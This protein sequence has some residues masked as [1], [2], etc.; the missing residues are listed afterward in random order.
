MASAKI[1]SAVVSMVVA[2][3]L[4]AGNAV[5][6]DNTSDWPQ[7]RGPNRDGVAP[8]GIK[9]VE[10]WPAKGP[11]QV[12][13]S[14]PIPSGQPGGLGSVAVAGGRAYVYVNWK[15]DKGH[16]DV[17]L[18]FDAATGKEIW[19]KEFPG[20]GYDWGCSAT[21][22]ILDD[23]CYV[24]ASDAKLYCL[25]AADG[26]LVWEAKTKHGGRV[27]SSVLALGSA[28]FA[29][30]GELM[31]FDKDSGK[32]LWS[33]PR[34]KA[35]ENSPVA[36]RHADKDYLI[37]NT[38]GHVFC[39]DASDGRVLWQANGGGCATAVVQG[40]HMV[41]YGNGL[42]AYALTLENALPLWEKN[43]WRDRGASAVIYSDHVYVVGGRMAC[44]DLKSGDVRWEK[45]VG[46]EITSPVLADNM[47][48]SGING[49]SDTVLLKADPAAFK[50]LSRVRL[51]QAAC[52]SPAIAG[53]K[54]FLRLNDGVACYDIQQYGAYLGE[55]SLQKHWLV[56]SFKKADDGLKAKT[57]DEGAIEGLSIT[58]ST[59]AV[60]PAKARVKDN[61]VAVSLKGMK[62]PLEVRY[63]SAT[64]LTTRGGEAV[65]PFR[66]ASTSMRYMR[67]TGNNLTF[68]FDPPVKGE[69]WGR[70]ELYTV[71]GA[72][73]TGVELKADGGSVILTTDKAWT[74]GDQGTVTCPWFA[75]DPS[76]G[77]RA[78]NAFRI[79]PGRVVG[80]DL[81]KEFLIGEVREKIDPNKILKEEV[82]D[83]NLK[84]TAGDKWKVCRSESNGLFDLNA[85]VG[86][87]SNVLAHACVYVY[88]Q[89]DR[90][91]QLWI[92]SDD[93]VKVLVNGKVVHLNPAMR[94]CT[95]D[96]DRVKDVSLVKGWNTIMMGIMQGGGG[97]AFCLRIR[98]KDGKV[99]T[100][101]TYGTGT[102]GRAK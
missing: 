90:K 24:T 4:C 84:P 77:G 92:G 35:T 63:D 42:K 81:L 93:G 45:R 37:C 30:G 60:T 76:K 41:V 83:K 57:K 80:E 62:P 29:M 53:G 71:S 70:K 23:R 55:V 82:L 32:Q 3:L 66:W 79:V 7:W 47:I 68:A 22:T 52:S 95:P 43:G 14:T 65:L 40:D 15:T 46:G 49:C 36:W 72:K 28:V 19:K 94:G 87:K 48:I 86:N 38:P 75:A 59:G 58:D 25:S 21:P 102:P 13:K 100:G 31:A 27:S 2:G 9:L 101:L 54:M 33:Q 44:V 78:E 50:E 12:W 11:R 10:E 88:A 34:V 73:I 6:A 26:E 18:C 61:T 39:V 64:G 99:P 8:S 89:E 51:G 67:C 96:Q 74:V 56:F 17:V 91:V 16:L 97:W 5:A 69:A 85:A 98:D 20:K 1:G